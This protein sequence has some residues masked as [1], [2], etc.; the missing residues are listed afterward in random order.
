MK[1]PPVVHGTFT[2]ERHFEASRARV[3][4]AWAD[5]DTKARWF[6]GP[7]DAWTMIERVLDL[8][9]G[10][11]EILHGRLA[12]G[13]ETRFV[14]RYHD[15]VPDQRLVYA[16]DMH[17]DAKHLSAS[18]AT[19]ELEDVKR[20][21]RM[22]FTE[23]AAFLDGEDGTASRRHGTDAH[24][25]RLAAV[26]E[27]AHEIV[28]HRVFDAPRDALY[29]AFAEPGRVEQWWGPSGFTCTQGVFDL[30]PGGEWGCVLHGPDGT[31][32]PNTK[33]FTEV[34]PSAR[35][36]FR[37]FQGVHTFTMTM[38]FLDLGTRSMLLWRMRFDAAEEAQRLRSIV[39]DAN[40]QNFD[41][42]AA[43]LARP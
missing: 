19:V 26:L 40:Q 42:L 14:A 3:F 17:H 34:V 33:T 5:I 20:G 9:V 18:L 28:S 8:R 39:E 30:R 7:P 43:H 29:R 10:G 37:H 25:E 6:I 12:S 15:I 23:Q 32:Y 11:T 24:F 38:T 2:L 22:T 21:T 36:A 31:D 35:V 27:D 16:Y 1:T 4:A 41:K 13:K